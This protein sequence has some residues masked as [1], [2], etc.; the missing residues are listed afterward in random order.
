M[1]NPLV[2]PVYKNEERPWGLITLVVVALIVGII[3]LPVQ[4]LTYKQLTEVSRT[5]QL[6]DGQRALCS[7]INAIA[8]QAH[9]DPTDCTAINAGK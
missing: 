9:L 1:S 8:A 2:R 6:Q 4:F 7:Q 5:K 3:G